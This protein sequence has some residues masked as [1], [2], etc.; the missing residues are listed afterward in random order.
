MSI[1]FVIA[2]IVIIFL[3]IVIIKRFVYFRPGSEWF[4]PPPDLFTLNRY[5]HISYLSSNMNTGSKLILFCGGNTGNVTHRLNKLQNLV[6]LGFNVVA[7]D[8]SGFGK[9]YGVPTEQ[10]LYDDASMMLS[11]ILQSHHPTQIVLYGEAMGAPKATYAARRYSIPTLILDSALP[12]AYIVAKGILGKILALP[13]KEFDTAKYLN[14]YKGKSLLIHSSEDEVM[15][16]ATIYNISQL[17]T[18]HIQ[19]TG[20]HSNPNIPWNK[21]KEFIQLN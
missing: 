1:E 16:Y 10:Q 8:Y 6:N 7:F 17:T 4:E 2:G 15:P 9:S 14:G 3:I 12:G 13:F 5:Q 19:T 18:K 21:I 20:T 11:L